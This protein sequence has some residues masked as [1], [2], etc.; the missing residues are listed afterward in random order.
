M[1][2]VVVQLNTFANLVPNQLKAAYMGRF[3][4]PI[5]MK[6]EVVVATR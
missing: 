4:A 3:R 1:P 2:K 6:R 5:A